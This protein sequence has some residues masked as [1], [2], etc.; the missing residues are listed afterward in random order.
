MK[1]VVQRVV[2]A[3]VTV[4]EELVSSIGR[5]L[6]VLVGISRDDTKK[7]MDYIVRKLINLRVF[8]GENGRRWDV[9]VKDKGYE[10]LCISQFTLYH[11]LKGNKLDFHNAMSADR[12]EAFYKAFLD[13]MRSQYQPELIKDGRFGAYMQVSMENDGPVT[14]V[15]E[16]PKKEEL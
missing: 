1:V 13:S 15:L 12:S 2:K 11:A 16:S 4:D 9:S 10:I 3:S 14:V 8:D 7:D 5:G 6:C